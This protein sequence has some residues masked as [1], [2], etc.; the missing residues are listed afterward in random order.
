MIKEQPEPEWNKW[1]EVNENAE[2]SQEYNVPSEKEAPLG[3]SETLADQDEYKYHQLTWE[4]QIMK[5]TQAKVGRLKVSELAKG[6][7]LPQST[8]ATNEETEKEPF[9]KD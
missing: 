5:E 3:K 2:N 7:D 8:P 4:K 6:C 9:H 1:R